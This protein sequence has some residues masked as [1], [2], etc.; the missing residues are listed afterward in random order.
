M[1]FA[2]DSLFFCHEKKEECQA[3]LGIL[4]EYDAVSGQQINFDKS[5]V[6]FGHKVLEHLKSQMMQILGIGTIG[7]MGSYL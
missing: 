2:D 3:I 7:G 4:K 1:L 6:K 5:S